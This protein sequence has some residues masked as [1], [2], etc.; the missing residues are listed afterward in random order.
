MAEKARATLKTDRANVIKTNANQEITA[1]AHGGHLDDILDSSWNKV[2][3]SWLSH[4]AYSTSRSYDI[5]DICVVAGRVLYAIE[6]TSGA[7][8]ASKWMDVNNDWGVARLPV[9]NVTAGSLDLES[10]PE[11]VLIVNGTGSVT[12]DKIINGINGRIYKLIPSSAITDLTFSRTAKATAI[13]GG[14]GQIETH[15]KSAITLGAGMV[16]ADQ[17]IADFVMLRYQNNAG[18]EYNLIFDSCAT[19]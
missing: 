2:T 13:S 17:A 16:D 8:D 7:F 19:F 10:R 12:V 11:P 3:E 4:F 6:A 14:T 18:K 15:T 9:V 1:L 5:S